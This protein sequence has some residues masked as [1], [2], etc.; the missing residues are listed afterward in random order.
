MT[1]LGKTVIY[2]YRKLFKLIFYHILR[3]HSISQ[4]RFKI[5]IRMSLHRLTLKLTLIESKYLL[6]LSNLKWN[7]FKAKTIVGGNREHG[8]SYTSPNSIACPRD[9]LTDSGPKCY[10]LTDWVWLHHRA[11]Q[12]RSYV[13]QKACITCSLTSLISALYMQRCESTN[14]K[15]DFL[16]F[17]TEIITIFRTLIYF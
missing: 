12:G 11:T 6:H 8:S 15:G 14:Q 13:E 3:H 9:F 7:L 5:V 2:A 4:R 10:I 16:D 1:T 17:W